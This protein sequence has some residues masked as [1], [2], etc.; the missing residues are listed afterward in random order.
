[1]RLSN[2]IVIVTGAGSGIGAGIAKRFA[3]EGARVV[4]N[5][6]NSQGGE[7][8]VAGIAGSKGKAIFA[9]ADVTTAAGWHSLIAAAEQNFG[10][11]DCV[12]NNAGWSHVN[13][14]FLEVTEADFDRC[15]T[16]NVKSIYL[17]AQAAL[18]VFRKQGRGG[19]IVNIASTAGVR[20]R[21]GLTVYNASKGAV[22]IMSKSMAAEFA[23]E[24]V[25]VNCVN[26]VFNPDTALSAAFAGG[27]VTDAM[28]EKFRASIPMGRF[29]TAE[30]V[31]NACLYLA[32]DEAAFITG[33][34]IEVDGGRCV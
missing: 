19:A 8:T 28:R 15:F 32:S 13:R 6:I 26:P 4:V 9:R 16:V 23:P 14:P 5:D 24:Q 29:S 11:L 18:P 33:V 7:A 22:V 30:D 10:G 1:M 3:A 21:P 20:P 2:K 27:A 34:N 12:I 25:R 17:S 31:A